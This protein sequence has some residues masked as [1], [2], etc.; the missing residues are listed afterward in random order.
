MLRGI[1]NAF[2]F[3]SPSVLG[4]QI[5]PTLCAGMVLPPPLELLFRWIESR[6]CFVDTPN[7]RIGFLF[8]EAEMKQGWA[9]NGRPGGK[10]IGFAAEVSRDNQDENARQS[11]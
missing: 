5:A 2:G 7:G 3:N 1:L 8:P 6:R 11:R 4:Q 9:D 10:D